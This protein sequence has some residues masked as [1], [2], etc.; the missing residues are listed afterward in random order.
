M[1][2]TVG[3]IQCGAEEMT[4]ETCAP[5]DWSGD[6]ETSA[7]E[8]S[9][10]D[11]SLM[12]LPEVLPTDPSESPL[13]CSFVR[14]SF[15]EKDGVIYTYG[16]QYV[17]CLCVQFVNGRCVIDDSTSTND[18]VY[19]GVDWYLK[20][21]PEGW[22][23]GDR[24][25]WRYGRAHG[26][27]LAWMPFDGVFSYGGCFDNGEALWEVSYDPDA[28][29]APEEIAALETEAL[30]KDCPPDAWNRADEP[31]PVFAPIPLPVTIPGVPSLPAID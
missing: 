20:N 15:H 28:L 23:L 5:C 4:E 30:T 25:K 22:K 11:S 9:A 21:T 10:P 27:W 17:E 13:D 18:Y 8:S 7:P 16:V 12:D 29:L 3:T 1:T 24:Y 2:L 31:P 26:R 19:H 14:T 6:G